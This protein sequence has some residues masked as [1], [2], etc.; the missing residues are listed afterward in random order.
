MEAIVPLEGEEVPPRDGDFVDLTPLLREDTFLGLPTK[1]LCKPECR[2]LARKAS[3]RDLCLGTP[4]GDGA[5]PWSELDK[6]KL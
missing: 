5:M 3:A 4:P 6:L 2:G 1:P